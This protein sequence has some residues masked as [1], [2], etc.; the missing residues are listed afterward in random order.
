MS[1][2]NAILFVRKNASWPERLT[3]AFYLCGNLLKEAMFRGR[4]RELAGFKLR[5][6]GVRDGLLRRPVPLRDI[7][8]DG[9]PRAVHAPPAGVSRMSGT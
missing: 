9:E 4:R 6:R 2:R 8:L 1:A 3:Y 7:G 5:L